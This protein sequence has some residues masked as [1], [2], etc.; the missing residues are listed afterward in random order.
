M[1][2]FPALDKFHCEQPVRISRHFRAGINDDRWC[3]KLLGV[4]GIDGVV[5]MV[6]T[7]D[8]VHRGIEVGTGVLATGKII[9]VPAR[10]GFIVMGNGLHLECPDLAELRWQLQGRKVRR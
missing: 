9:P 6:L 2:A 3:D 7:G 8:P 10:A 1:H 4:D 5:C